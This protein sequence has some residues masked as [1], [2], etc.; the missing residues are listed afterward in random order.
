VRDGRHA[1]PDP[2][3]RG[4]SQPRGDSPGGAY[5]DNY[6]SSS[7]HHLRPSAEHTSAGQA[8]INRALARAQQAAKVLAASRTTASGD[9]D[10]AVPRAERRLLR[11]R[12]AAASRG[13]FYLSTGASAHHTA[14]SEFHAAADASGAETRLRLIQNTALRGSAAG[15]AAGSRATAAAAAAAPGLDFS[16]ASSVVSTAASATYPAPPARKSKWAADERGMWSAAPPAHSGNP[17]PDGGGA[18]GYGSDDEDRGPPASSSSGSGGGGVASASPSRKHVP[19]AWTGGA[20]A[21]MGTLAEEVAQRAVGFQQRRASSSASSS[22]SS[23]AYASSALPSPMQPPPPAHRPSLAAAAAQVGTPATPPPA[24]ARRAVA[25][26]LLSQEAA[27]ASGAVAENRLR[28]QQAKLH[29]MQARADQVLVRELPWRGAKGSE[30]F[31]HQRTPSF[32][33]PLSLSL[34]TCGLTANPCMAR[35]LPRTLSPGGL[36]A[37]R[38]RRL[39]PHFDPP[40]VPRDHRGVKREK[41]EKRAVDGFFSVHPDCKSQNS[42]IRHTKATTPKSQCRS[43]LNNPTFFLA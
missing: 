17:N 41:R 27:A 38:R 25:E 1:S 24:R 10:S 11:E 35:P 8:A 36:P 20:P 29:R 2:H 14:A 40:V 26:K 23:S 16:A 21:G 43:R 15:P 9:A 30:L 12:E 13:E 18:A 6:G 4:G 28:R 7:S 34:S 22:S 3:G 33:L 5:G 37:P 42:G 32:S 19:A 31:S 39:Q